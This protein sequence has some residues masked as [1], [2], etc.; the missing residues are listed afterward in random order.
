MNNT[1]NSTP[2]PEAL[3][4]GRK[5]GARELTGDLV[6]ELF[7]Q[8]EKDVS[9]L[10]MF[11]AFAGALQHL[12][13]DA[14][15]AALA[16]LP[17]R[18]PDGTVTVRVGAKRSYCYAV[19]FEGGEAIEVDVENSRPNSRPFYRLVWRKGDEKGMSMRAAIAVRA[20][21]AKATGGSQ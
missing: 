16:S 8:F 7:E 12:W 3:R 21:I 2:E 18:I 17:P 13:E 6:T 4:E 11:G 19:I 20:A 5:S 10:G 1:P 14:Q 15:E 9:A